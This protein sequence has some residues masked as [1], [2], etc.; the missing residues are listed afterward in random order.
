MWSDWSSCDAGFGVP[1]RTVWYP[2]TTIEP[3]I[4]AQFLEPIK[5]LI[6][7]NPSLGYQTAAHRLDTNRNTIQR[8]F[9]RMGCQVRKRPLEGGRVFIGASSDRPDRAPGACCQVVL[10]SIRQRTGLH[11]TQLH[12]TDQ[13]LRASAGLDRSVSPEQN[14]MVVRA[15]RAHKELCAQRH[16]FETP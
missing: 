14:G 9:Q 8:V 15:I 10:T 5:A 4:Q 2:L 11:M 3:K 6:E 12:G 7:E 1:R 13:K 16:C